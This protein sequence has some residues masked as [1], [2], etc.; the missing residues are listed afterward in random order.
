MN[1][2]R[3]GRAASDKG[4]APEADLFAFFDR[5]DAE[6]MANEAKPF[7]DPAVSWLYLMAQADDLHL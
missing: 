2:A 7:A 3:M 1:F 4:L 6:N 5:R